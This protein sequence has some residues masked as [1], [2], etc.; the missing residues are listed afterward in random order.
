MLNKSSFIPYLKQPL[1]VLADSLPLGH[2][3]DVR[4]CIGTLIWIHC[5][6]FTQ[7][8]FL[9]PSMSFFVSPWWFEGW[10]W[11]NFKAKLCEL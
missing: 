1:D 9:W 10:S 5:L 2:F 7:P 8:C 4:N 3:R 11:P 6:V